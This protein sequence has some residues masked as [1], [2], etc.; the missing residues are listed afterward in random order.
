[1]SE[2]EAQP[3]TV[4]AAQKSKVESTFI[5]K[6]YLAAINMPNVFSLLS[7]F[8]PYLIVFLIL[9]NSI[10]NSNIKGLIYL[11]GI[12]I[13]FIF[14]LFFQKMLMGS[15]MLNTPD[16]M[17]TLF[18]LNLSLNSI[19]SFNVSLI[20]YTLIYLLVPMIVNKSINYIFITVLS[21]ILISSTIDRIYKNCTTIL[22]AITGGFL[23]FVWGILYY[24]IIS[25]TNS[26][27]TYYDDFISNKVACS[28]PTE[29]KFKCSVYKNGELLQTI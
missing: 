12:L 27:L 29:Q 20:T 15:D 17:C 4:T 2:A 8:S 24:M 28:R 23:G 18:N 25:S 14:V 22:G 10:I 11:C 21:I 19:P 26:N 1:M 9:F 16:K 3:T 7:L 6:Q 13:L 5:N